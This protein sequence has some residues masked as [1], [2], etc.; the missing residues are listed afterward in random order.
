VVDVVEAR[1]DVTLEHVDVA[2]GG[3]HV[4]LGDRVVRTPV[5][6]EPVGARQDLLGR[7]QT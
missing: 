4:H 1:L 3:E 7:P 5:R 2:L 6:S